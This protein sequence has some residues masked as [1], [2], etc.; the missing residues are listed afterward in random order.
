M[1]HLA[2]EREHPG[3][4][5]RDEKRGRGRVTMAMP[6]S[7]NRQATTGMPVFSPDGPDH[8]AVS[9]MFDTT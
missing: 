8:Q 6:L 3:S 1:A 5:D 4:L 7:Q 2:E 9:G